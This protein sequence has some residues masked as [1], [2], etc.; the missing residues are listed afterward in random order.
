MSKIAYTAK[1]EITEKELGEM[2]K[3]IN[4][5]EY[6]EGGVKLA[7]HEV[8]ANPELL[9]TICEV[10]YREMALDDYSEIWAADMWSR[11]ELDQMR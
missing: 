1:V 9:K 11:C 5:N 4:D 10:G 3:F 8:L 7:L 2:I 6:D